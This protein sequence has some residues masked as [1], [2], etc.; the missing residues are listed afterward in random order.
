MCINSSS[1]HTLNL[2]IQVEQIDANNL[3]FL[4]S[5]PE[6]EY[7]VLQSIF[8][9]Y[10]MCDLKGQKLSR[11]QKGTNSSTLDCKPSNFKCLRGLEDA[12]RL[13]LL[14]QV[15]EGELSFRELASFC[16]YAKKM[17]EVQKR[18]LMYH[19]LTSWED[20]KKTFPHHATQQA[21]E[22]FVAMNFSKGTMPPAFV[23]FC[24]SALDQNSDDY[25][26][27]G[28]SI[29]VPAAKNNASCFLLDNSCLDNSTNG[30]LSLLPANFPGFSLSV[31]YFVQVC[32][33][34]YC[35]LDTYNYNHGIC[36]HRIQ[37]PQPNCRHSPEL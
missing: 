9:K 29:A 31:L 32:T 26:P 13:S 15:S 35:L 19:S 6:E 2:F 33:C 36:S 30:M 18:F 28:L 12:T 16:Q 25:I 23:Q 3:Y 1:Y 14:K 22:P 17:S 7:E 27:Q 5:L 11:S 8:E 34:Y 4:A 21:L 24:K 37:P 20:A 10:E